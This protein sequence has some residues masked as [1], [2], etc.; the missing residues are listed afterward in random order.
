MKSKSNP[1][2]FLL[3]SIVAITVVASSS[4]DSNKKSTCGGD[5]FGDEGSF[6]FAGG[7][8]PGTV[9][10]WTIHLESTRDFRLS[11]E[12]I[13][14]IDGGYDCADGGVRIYSLSNLLDA[15]KIEAYT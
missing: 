11:F 6:T 9:C 5:H 1:Q 2:Y 13:G 4:A 12:N 3:L 10:V 8:P 14:L 15:D 7:S